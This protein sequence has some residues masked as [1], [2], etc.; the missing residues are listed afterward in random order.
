MGCATTTILNPLPTT[1]ALIVRRRSSPSATR[2]QSVSDSG[3]AK[4]WF[5]S[6]KFSRAAD[7]QALFVGPPCDTHET[8]LQV[9]GNVRHEDE[10]T[11]N[12]TIAI[13]PSGSPMTA[14]RDFTKQRSGDRASLDRP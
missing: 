13:T 8:V 6:A 5:A 9:R 2:P 3:S 7:V 10:R 11:M 14:T 4:T 12:G 1:I